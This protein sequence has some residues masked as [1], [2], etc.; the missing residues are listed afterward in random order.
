MKNKKNQLLIIPGYLIGIGS[1]FIITY[2]TLLAF[3]SD[4]RVIMIYVNKYGEQYADIVSLVILW[5][6]CL[7]GLYFTMRQSR[8]IL[9]EG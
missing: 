9:Q 6:I 5:A 7:V 8:L 1:L 3:F 2:R 4:S